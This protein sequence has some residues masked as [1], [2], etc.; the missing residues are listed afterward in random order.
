MQVTATMKRTYSKGHLCFE[1]P[2]DPQLRTL[3]ADLLTICSK[4]DAD[5]VSVT[6]RRP[7]KP[8]TTGPKSQNHHLN[9]HILQLCQE[10]GNDYDS[11]KNAVKMLAVTQLG[12]PYVEI[13]GQIVPKKESDSSTEECALLIEATHL[14]AADLGLILREE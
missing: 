1:V 14:V 13:A 10:T 8:R 2:H 12:Y 9:G 6:L 11:V 7:R 3:L 4:K 5:Y